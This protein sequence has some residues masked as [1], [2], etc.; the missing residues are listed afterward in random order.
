MNE[1]ASIVSKTVDVFT[2]SLVTSFIIC[3]C[4]K[5]EG[6]QLNFLLW[7]SKVL[8]CIYNGACVKLSFARS[9]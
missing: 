8:C 6:G 7:I 4:F 1:T 9:D 2:N 5:T 3:C